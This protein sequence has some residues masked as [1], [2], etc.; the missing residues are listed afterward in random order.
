MEKG[1]FNNLR[2]FCKKDHKFFVLIRMDSSNLLVLHIKRGLHYFDFIKS[3]TQD[4][5]NMEWVES[6]FEG[7]ASFICV[8][9]SL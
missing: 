7:N 3:D 5:A 2:M 8:F 4:E 9:I 6:Y 1:F